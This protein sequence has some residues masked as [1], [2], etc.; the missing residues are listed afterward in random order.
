[1]KH[2]PMAKKPSAVKPP[3][4]AGMLIDD[5]VMVMMVVVRVTQRE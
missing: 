4:R 3:T 2:T 1:M 5:M